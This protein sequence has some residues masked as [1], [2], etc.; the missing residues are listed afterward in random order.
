MKAVRKKHIGLI[1]V[2]AATVLGITLVGFFG[3]EPSKQSGFLTGWMT[4]ILVALSTFVII[5]IRRRIKSTGPSR[6]DESRKTTET[7]PTTIDH[8]DS[9]VR[10]VEGSRWSRTYLYQRVFSRILA[11]QLDNPSKVGAHRR[12]M[13]LADIESVLDLIEETEDKGK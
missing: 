5:W 12:R 9:L 1:M 3:V 7:K 10:S 6:F 2:G 8:W 4:F 13:G 11:T